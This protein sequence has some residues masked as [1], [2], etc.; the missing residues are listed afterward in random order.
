MDEGLIGL[1]LLGGEAAELGED[2]RGDADG[3]ELFGAGHAA[4]DSKLPQMMVQ[5]LVHQYGPLRRR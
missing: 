1:V 2:A 5:M 3:D 4:L